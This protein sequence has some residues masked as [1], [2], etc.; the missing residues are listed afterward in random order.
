M[1]GLIQHFHFSLGAMLLQLALFLLLVQNVWAQ[2]DC[3]TDGACLQSVMIDQT[4]AE[5]PVTCENFCKNNAE[6]VWFTFYADEGVCVALTE[7]I[8]VTQIPRTVSGNAKCNSNLDCDVRGRCTGIL[9]NVESAQTSQNCQS[10]CQS[11]KDCKWFTHDS[12]SNVCYNFRDCVAVNEN[13]LTC[14]SGEAN[15][16]QKKAIIRIMIG[17]GMH[18][19]DMIFEDFNNYFEVLNLDL[20]GIT[21]QQCSPIPSIPLTIRGGVGIAAPANFDAE[22]PTVC[23]GTQLD[24]VSN[25]CWVLYDKLQNLTRFE[26]FNKSSNY[27]WVEGPP[28][29]EA[30]AHA[31]SV[32]VLEAGLTSEWNWWVSGGF[33]NKR[34]ALK[35]SEIRWAN[36]TWGPGPQMPV[37]VYGHCVVQISRQKS[38]VIGGTPLG[39]N[40][41]FDWSTK[42]LLPNF[43]IIKIFV[44]NWFLAEME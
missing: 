2:N 7:C 6:C 32:K 20:N 29:L 1:A 5:D 30:R 3:W 10:I 17:G 19:E 33:D 36:G 44:E 25:E 42:V 37:P 28:M 12:A 15:C 31:A 43:Q 34:N 8:K 23:G 16:P 27:E 39:E 21:D 4:P 35:T 18:N 41:L 9:I 38:V 40:W 22:S 13:C 14:T 11:T 26:Y 24:I